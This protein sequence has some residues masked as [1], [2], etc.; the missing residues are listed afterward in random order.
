MTVHSNSDRMTASAPGGIGNIGPGLDVLGCAL[1]GLRD[2]VT[3]E[4]HDAPGVTVRSTGHP[5][6]PTDPL[7]HTAALAAAA[8]LRL[9][10]RDH[11]GVPD[12]GLVID[13]RKSLPLLG[14]QGGSS[15]SAVAG[16]VATN[17][18]LG[19]LLDQLALLECCLAAEEIVAGRHLDNIAPSLLGGIVL[20]RS[21]D[22]IDIVRLPV[23]VALRFVIAQ[24]QQ[25]LATSA[26]RDVLPATVARLVAQ[27]QMAQVGAMVAACCT[28]DLALFGRAIDDRIA[29]P[30]R[31]TLLPGFVEA[32]T[33][34]LAAGALGVSISG[35]GP[36]AFAVVNDED[37]GTRVGR[38][39]VEGYGRA[40]VQCTIRITTVDR[41]GAIARPA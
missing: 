11:A 20:V 30:V 24:P 14:G 36:S 23:P 35:A 40:G 4:W 2:E 7:R 29:E 13:A 27:H 38:A 31:S 25:R 17:A 28:G 21:M 19:G 26:S 18:L 6:L 1:A 37:A 39:M 3:V 15:A 5:D 33:A 16:A 41:E 10:R 12:R 22:P 34:A 32:K 8:V 9:A